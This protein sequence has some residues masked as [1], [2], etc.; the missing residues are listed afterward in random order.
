MR[1]STVSC[2]LSVVAVLV[3]GNV[4]ADDATKPAIKVEKGKTTSFVVMRTSESS[5]SRGESKS[6]TETEYK[7]TL[8]NKKD[9]GDLVF[10]VA[11]A[12]L[13]VKR[14]GGRREFSFD[15][16]DKDDDSEIAEAIRKAIAKPITVTVSGGAIKD[17]SG[18]PERERPAAGE[19][20]RFRGGAGAYAGEGTLR[21]DLD[22]IFATAVQGKVLEK[23]KSYTTP[24]RQRDRDGGGDRR[25]RGGF[26]GGTRL[27]F[28]FEG[29]EKVTAKF[30]LAAA[31][32]EPRPDD[33]GDRP[34]F[35]R[36]EKTK[37]VATLSLKDGFL[38]KLDLTTDS[39]VSGEFNGNEFSFETKTTMKISRRDSK[40]PL[41]L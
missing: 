14:E 27:A 12:S 22:V 31:P 9:S 16:G 24:R 18:F 39:K 10:T 33:D 21:R 30:A 7:V 4:S 20:R 35:E 25:R 26:G 36:K 11:Y 3:W 13:R 15:S 28:T 1:R 40:K 38:L 17:I 23:G 29:V 34:R 37:G 2:V 19:R 6:T 8:T 5:S 41:R 32:R